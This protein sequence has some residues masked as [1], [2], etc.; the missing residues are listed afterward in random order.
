MKVLEEAN[1]A[2]YL[3]VLSCRNIL[4]TGVV[5]CLLS[6][7]ADAAQAEPQRKDE[8]AAVRDSS[9]F[10]DRIVTPEQIAAALRPRGSGPLLILGW[11]FG[12]L[13]AGMEKGLIS[14][15]KNKIREKIYDIQQ[16]LGAA[17]FRP[18]FG[19]LGEG[20]GMG[21]GTVYQVPAVVQPSPEITALQILGRVAPLSGYQEFAANFLSAP[22]HESSLILL[23]NYQWRPNEPYYGF[24]Q[25]SSVEDASSFA[26]RQTSLAARWEFA[27]VR[28][29]SFGTEYSVAVLKA[30]G[31]TRGPRPSADQVFGEDL[32]G[33]NESVRLQSV[34][35]FFG[36]NG[37]RGEYGM[38]GRIQVGA[39]WQDSLGEGNV[40]Y[41]R[42]EGRTEGRLPVAPGRSVLIA[43]A[44]TEMTREDTGGEPLPFYLYP[45]IGGS[46][47]L[48]GF[49]LDRF[50]GRNM[51]FVTLEYRVA[52]HPNVDF[53]V[54]F[55]EG[56]IYQ[57]TED[58]NFKDWHRNYGVG[59]RFNNTTG[60]QFRIELAT[61]SEGF[62]LHISFGDRL[63]RP[64]GGPVR[65][66]NYRP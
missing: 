9:A 61:S 59:F 31:S 58:L 8:S 55:D 12:K 41:A 64:L 66:P 33:L 37:L 20:S 36:A 51:I 32:N 18:L 3:E 11:P 44:A 16:K 22:I 30:L 60:T 24:G 47:T 42:I 50:Y 5:L 52:I 63:P 46:S 4:R 28:R 39:S 27:P 1:V 40:R 19:G 35:A 38:G 43:Q 48:R 6:L 21:L 25:D 17:G 14:F 45:R 62:T 29:V 13:F 26:L 54:F 65:Y 34:G 2:H 23:A 53:Q 15:E 49:T 7:C 10:E 57:H 56:Q